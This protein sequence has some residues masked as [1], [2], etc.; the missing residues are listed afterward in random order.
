MRLLQL[1]LR[2]FLLYSIILVLFSIPISL[3]SIRAI[4]NKE[5]DR[6][7]QHQSEEF[8]AHIKRFEYLGDL[9]TDLE[10][11]D[12]LSNNIHIKPFNGNISERNFQTVLIYDSAEQETK[13]FRELSSAVSV[14]N[15]PYLLTVRMSL[16]GNED[17]L[18]TIGLAQ[19]ALV[20]LLVSGLFFLNRSLSKRLWRPFYKTLDQLKAYQLDKAEPV[21]IEKSNIA[22]FDDLNETVRHLSER[23]RKIYLQQKEF[24][25]N[26]SH[27]LQTPIAIFQSKLDQLMQEPSLNQA[28]AILINELEST[29]QRMSRINKN[30][31]LLSKIDNEQY[32]TTDNIEIAELVKHQISELTQL[33]ESANIKLNSDEQPSVVVANKT[34]IEILI[35]NLLL[36]ALR[37]SP[38]NEDIQ[39]MLKD[40][41]LSIVNKGE[42]LKMDFEK[43]TERFM[44]A[45]DHPTSTGL[46]LSIVKKICD[47]Y[48][49]RLVYHY[50]NH[51]H[52]FMVILKSEI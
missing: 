10:V 49:Y 45:S 30:L 38:K 31:L 48:G 3:F 32:L 22:E 14:K 12:N 6:T 29:A 18:E 9:E 20:I 35:F 2:S 21:T 1:S 11:L 33:T 5:V 27:E 25:E 16:V 44:K 41:K 26:A 46:G 23:N 17:L 51:A 4:L 37:F 7:I 19:V 34:L 15:K 39:V 52:H 43:L 28:S 13:P 47:V 36:N 42:P 24:I 50:V 8:V 40:D